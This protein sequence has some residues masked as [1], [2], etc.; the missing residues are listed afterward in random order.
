[1]L[2]IYLTKNQ[3]GDNTLG[4]FGHFLVIMTCKSLIYM[5]RTERLDVK[6]KKLYRY[7]SMT[8]TYN[9]MPYWSLLGLIGLT[10]VTFLVTF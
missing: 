8:Y 10:L 7:K 5:V 6:I 2:L 3:P 4:H 1:M 9:Y